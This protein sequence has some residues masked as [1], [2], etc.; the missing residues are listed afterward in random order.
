LLFNQ[1]PSGRWRARCRL[2]TTSQS[3]DR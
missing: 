2:S 3:D 1:C